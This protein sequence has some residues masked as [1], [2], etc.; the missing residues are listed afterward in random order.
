MKIMLM[1]KV[2]QNPDAA[3]KSPRRESFCTNTMVEQLAHSQKTS[4]YDQC[5]IN[6]CCTSVLKAPDGCMTPIFNVL[7]IF[8]FIICHLIDK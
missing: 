1:I 7:L 5:K 8:L 2:L 3:L 6:L 4:F